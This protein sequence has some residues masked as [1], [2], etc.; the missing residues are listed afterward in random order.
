MIPSPCEVTV[1]VETLEPQDQTHGCHQ[2]AAQR[3]ADGSFSWA[4]AVRF[5]VKTSTTMVIKVQVVSKPNGW[6]L[7]FSTSASQPKMAINASTKQLN[8]QDL[9]RASFQGA[10]HFSFDLIDAVSAMVIGKVILKS[11]LQNT[12]IRSLPLK[13]PAY[14]SQYGGSSRPHSQGGG[15][16]GMTRFPAQTGASS[17]YQTNTAHAYHPMQGPEESQYPA[18]AMGGS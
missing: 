13:D 14:Q 9:Q 1:T 11:P 16:A 6:S 5:E 8:I 17:Q 3:I 4:E 2:L 18:G 15:G 10:E 7:W 12:M